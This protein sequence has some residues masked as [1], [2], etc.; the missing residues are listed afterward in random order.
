[1]KLYKVQFTNTI[2][3]N[4]VTVPTDS[5]FLIGL[6]NG[7]EEAVVKLYDGDT[8]IA[9]M[10]DKIGSY[11]V[12]RFTT[13]GNPFRKHYK[14]TFTKTET[15]EGI[16]TVIYSVLVDILVICV[17]L[18]VAYRDFEGGG[19]SS[20]EIVTEINSSSTDEQVPSAKCVYDIVGDVETLINNI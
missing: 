18:S 6:S 9:P 1:M 17:N 20:V 8:E 13:G 14:G 16:T 11:T 5:E 7:D 3:D 15:V 2:G 10:E 19:G 4:V 12:F